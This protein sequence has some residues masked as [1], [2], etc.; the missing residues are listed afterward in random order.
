MLSRT[1]IGVLLSVSDVADRL[2]LSVR[3]V[4]RLIRSGELKS[5]TIHS[6]VRVTES[7]LAD[8]LEGCRSPRP[9]R[10]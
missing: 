3:T 9:E 8:F 2:N 4:R 5:F 6:R 10:S 7:D 1:P